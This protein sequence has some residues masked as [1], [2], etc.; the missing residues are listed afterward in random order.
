M[1]EMKKWLNRGYWAKEDLKAI[2]EERDKAYAD[3]F[4]RSMGNDEKV[5][6]S[7]IN[8]TEKRYIE[9][10][11]LEGKLRAQS[12]HIGEILNEIE[13]VIMGVSD[14]RSRTLLRRRYILFKNWNEIADEMC[15]DIR[16]IHRIH[17]IALKEAEKV[18][19]NMS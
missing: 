15:Y 2:R 16:H 4:G 18:F 9:Y 6:I 17:E 8:T 7:K 19:K 12:E 3:I 5:Q 1:V 11:E 10:L 13:S 14:Y